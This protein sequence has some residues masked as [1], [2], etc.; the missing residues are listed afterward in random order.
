MTYLQQLGAMIF[1]LAIVGGG[2]GTWIAI[3]IIA[4]TASHEKETACKLATMIPLLGL[5]LLIFG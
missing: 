2:I 5:L 3:L 1:F 4:L